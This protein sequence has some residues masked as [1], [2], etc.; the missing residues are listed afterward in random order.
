MVGSK[1]ASVLIKFFDEASRGD[2]HLTQTEMDQTSSSEEGLR[3][4]HETFAYQAKPRDNYRLADKRPKTMCAWEF[5]Q[6]I[7]QL[8]AEE[9]KPVF[10]KKE[11]DKARKK[12]LRRHARE[13]RYDSALKV[14]LVKLH[15]TL[16]PKFQ[17]QLGSDSISESI[18]VRFTIQKSGAVDPESINFSGSTLK[19]DGILN[20][21]REGLASTSFGALPEGASRTIEYPLDFETVKP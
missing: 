3:I 5:R 21:L 20:L 8:Y 7:N 15:R 6:A 18:K 16:A 19:N 17:K 1:D 4:L 12:E 2:G 11:I 9:E 13:E 14:K 10:L